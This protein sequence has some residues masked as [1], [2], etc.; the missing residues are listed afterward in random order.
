MVIT[1]ATR[2]RVAREGTWVRI[3]PS[4]PIWQSSRAG[5]LKSGCSAAR[6]CKN[7]KCLFSQK[8]QDAKNIWRLSSAGRALASHARGRWFESS[9]LHHVAANFAAHKAP[10]RAG[11][12]T[13]APLLLLFREKSRLLRLCPCKR[14]HN[15]FAALPTFLGC[16]T[17]KPDHFW[18]VKPRKSHQHVSCADGFF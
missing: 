1:S 5:T 11:A 12:L 13:S 15:A 2:N 17:A 7:H 3:P 9:S 8:R 16:V 10:A 6:H 18:Q 4:P 14:G